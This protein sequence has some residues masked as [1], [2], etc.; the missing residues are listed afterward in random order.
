MHIPIQ[1]NGNRTRKASA[2]RIAYGGGAM[3]SV[4]VL[5]NSTVKTVEFVKD[6]QRMEGGV[7]LLSEDCAVNAKSVVGV[8]S[9]DLSK[10]V[11]LEIM[12]WKEEYAA[13]ISKYL[14]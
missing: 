11:K 2:N 5:L 12:D 3:K 6:M 7:M 4:Y 8:F 13:L 10:P 1:G 14:A 9:M